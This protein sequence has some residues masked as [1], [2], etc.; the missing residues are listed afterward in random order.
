[1][2]VQT[3]MKSRMLFSLKKRGIYTK[4]TDALKTLPMY[5]HA[6]RNSQVIQVLR[7]S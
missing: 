1:M 7:W 4:V 3:A 5:Q 2:S 6:N